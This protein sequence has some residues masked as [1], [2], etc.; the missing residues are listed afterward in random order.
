MKLMHPTS[1][2]FRV[3]HQLVQEWRAQWLLVLAWLAVVATDCW[4]SMQD[5]RPEIAMPGFLPGLLAL[6]VIVR[7]V[8]ADGPGNTEAG[9]HVRPLGRGAVWMA[10]VVFFKV[11][12]LLP[13]L[14]SD[15]VQCHGYGYGAAEWLAESA[16]TALPAL[17]VG[18]CAALI[19]SWSGPV[20]RNMLGGLVCIVLL[21]IATWMWGT[22]WRGAE[23]VCVLAV[24]RFI[25]ILTLVC[26]WWQV[27]LRRRACMTL[28]AGCV[29]AL[30]TS[31]M[32]NWNW[33]ARPEMRYEDA[34]LA[35]HIGE[36]PDGGTQELWKGVHVTGLPAD[37]VASVAA[38][39]PVGEGWPPETAFSGYT[40]VSGGETAKVQ[41]RQRWMVM[42]HT[43][44]LVPHYPSGE[45]WRGHADDVRVEELQKIV[46]GAAPGP[47]R[48]RLA[49]QRMK[50]VTTMPLRVAM[51]QEQRI[52]LEA[53]RRL[54]FQMSERDHDSEM[55]FRSM[56]RRRIPLLAAAGQQEA[57]R[58]AGR[59]PEENF[60]LLLHSPGIREVNTAC[61]G[62]LRDSS[63]GGQYHRVNK[64]EGHFHFA[65]PRAQM[66]IAGLKFDEW[67]DGTMLD[68]WWTEERGVVDL[69]VSGEE[70]LR[71]V[72]GGE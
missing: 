19:A 53:G 59:V 67:V 65:H 6:T 32:G 24:G 41:M 27:T 47:W 20:W 11:T 17:Y 14:T 60:L 31:G 46:S 12:L 55:Q 34:K 48:L 26:A 43:Q 69:E 44:A 51:S 50:R 58:V 7:S 4:Q 68:V 39:A 29:A 42:A 70:L 71:V 54:D 25:L 2:V 9:A 52:V 8:R 3:W 57:L 40:Q 63:G 64:R 23:N 35:L 33:R 10:K 22:V 18:G 56:L 16:G 66:D 36:R 5:E 21:E 30:L 72:K 1:F 15:W 38:F 62:E 45:L 49:V 37:H 13:W 61:E 28:T